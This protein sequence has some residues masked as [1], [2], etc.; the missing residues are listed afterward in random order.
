MTA[1]NDQE[2]HIK[3]A[4]VHNL[5]DVEIRIPRDRMVVVTGLSGSGKSSLAFDTLYAEGQ[6]R[7]VE[8]LS[9][10]ARQFLGRIDKPDVDFI[11]G[12]PPAVA[13]EQRVNT[14][15]PRSTVGT[16]TEIY[17][18]IK[19]LYARAGQTYS[20]ISGKL[21]KRHS[22]SDVVD[23]I[24]S[25]E[26]GKRYVILSSVELQED[27]DVDYQL[28]I[29]AGQGMSRAK[30][31]NEIVSMEEMKGGGKKLGK[32]P[33]NLVVDRIVVQ[34]D[35]DSVSRFG[36]SVQTALQI[37][38]GHCTIW[39]PES[40][41]MEEFS[42][43]FEA[44]GMEF[45]ESS[46]HLFTFN[47]PLGACHSCEGYGKM[48]GIDEE[49]VIPDKR[50]SVYDDAIV[51]WKGE[52]MKKW[53]EKLLMNAEQFGFPIHEPIHQLSKEQQQLLWTGNRYFRGLNK[54]FDHLEAK[55]YKIQYRVM[56]SRYRGKTTCPECGGS[57][58][59]KE[60]GYVKVGGRMI[61]ELV[62]LPITELE[63]YF[64]KLKQPRKEKEV[65]RRLLKEINTRIRFMTSVGLGYLT[66]NRLSSTLS[67][68]ESQ[69]INL[70]TS[71]GS[72]LVG[73]LYI[74]DE[75][76]IGL[77]SR[78]T[79]QLIGVL[80]ELQQL[81]NTVLIVE[82]DEE[83]IRAADHVIDMGPMAGRHGGEVVFE[84]GHKALLRNNKSLTARYMNGLMEIPVPAVRR[85][86]SNYLK[87]TGARENNL[88]GVDV[89]FP[90]N[91]FT[92]VTGVSGSGKSSLISSIL[93][94][95]LNKKINGAGEKPGKHDL[96]EGD[97][98]LID[99][100]EFVDQNPIGKSSRSNPVTYLKAFD[101]I[102]KLFAAQQAS[103]INGLKASHFSFNID[104]GRCDECQG[105][106]EIKVEMQFMADVRLL[107]DSCHGKRFKDEVLQVEYRGRSIYDVLQMTIN[108]AIEFFSEGEGSS[109]RQ[110]TRKLK[111]LQQV[112]LG[113]VKLGQSSSTLSGGE[114]QR[115][116]L[117]YFLSKDSDTEK[118]LFIFDE[119]T[120]GLHMHDISLLL[121]S[122]ESLLEKGHTVLVIEHNLEVIKSADWI[123]D[124]GPE[125]GSQGG[126][127]IY[128]GLPEKMPENTHTGHYLHPKLS[129]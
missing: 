6:R 127:I 14:K 31:G 41:E 37:G 5:K 70:A 105:E 40:G 88:L 12:I 59:R 85:K 39:D 21:V 52:K 90:L 28:D 22:V 7:Y 66:L 65:S 17:D 73:S 75:P 19:L 123:I 57:R 89:K 2:I 76:S 64:S 95:A 33:L 113:Y 42:T 112:G 47:N 120:T 58:L 81:G 118:V 101:E 122:M 29:Y 15:N 27:K 72:S 23:Y 98:H 25:R 38:H 62:Q 103:K 96:L 63:Q 106:G 117:A 126:K 60:A 93:Y 102:R 48:I 56:L 3:G 18:Y 87:I 108:E 55:K 34:S 46:E 71:L 68:G 44:D 94:P 116:K 53:K 35:E 1:I 128:E 50:L 49:L 45:E 115:V 13:L 92:V 11:H 100:V 86:W 80:R 84:G 16:S 78:D 74:L 9:A 77:H 129:G 26:G 51:C 24:L 32:L 20:P 10:Y 111:P 97:L 36:D 82:H 54:F 99:R 124:L 91:V 119:P 8:S 104:G 79:D 61:T 110:I 67:G 83:I 114:S 69:R 43:R 107:C 4:R 125:G 109:E 121:S 30:V